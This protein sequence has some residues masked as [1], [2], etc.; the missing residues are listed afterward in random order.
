MD[1]QFGPKEEGFQVWPENWPAVEAFLAVQTQW[2]IG[3]A[4]PTGLDYTRVRAGLE[5]AGMQVTP[6]LFQKL[7]ILESAALSALARKEKK[8]S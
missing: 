6:E 4:G 2:S 3:M 7:R 1:A 8:G 5:L